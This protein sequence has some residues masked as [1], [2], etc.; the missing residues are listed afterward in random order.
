MF[1]PVSP[2]TPGA[3]VRKT[4]MVISMGR[5]SSTQI[6]EYLGEGERE[7]QKKWQQGERGLVSP[8]R[9]MISLMGHL[10]SD[11][12]LETFMLKLLL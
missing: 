3:G 10:N 6:G 4:R 2:F 9:K 12:I 5:D 1:F 7:E 8:V 11:I